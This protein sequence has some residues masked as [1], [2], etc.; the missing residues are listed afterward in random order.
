MDIFATVLAK[1]MC[2]LSE[3]VL[4]ALPHQ[5]KAQI[6]FQFRLADKAGSY[7]EGIQ[8]HVGIPVSQPLNQ[9]LDNLLRSICVARYFVAYFDN[10]TPVF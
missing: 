4:S 2:K 6:V 9:A 1:R 3:V 8:L 5:V 10:S 7:L